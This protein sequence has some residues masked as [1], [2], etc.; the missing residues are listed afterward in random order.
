MTQHSIT[1]TNRPTFHMERL[2]MVLSHGA[3]LLAA[4]RA[5]DK[6]RAALADLSEEIL[7]DIALTPNDTDARLGDIH[8]R[9]AER[10]GNW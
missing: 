4:I 7:R 6:T 1:N 8:D 9:R 5:R 2:R 10:R 3:A